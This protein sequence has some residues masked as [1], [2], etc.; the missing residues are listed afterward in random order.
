MACRT[1]GHNRKYSNV[2][3]QNPFQI[4]QRSNK[5]FL[6]SISSNLTNKDT[7]TLLS[8]RSF[9]DWDGVYD[10]PANISLSLCIVLKK[11]AGR[12]PILSISYHTDS[13]SIA[14]FEHVHPPM[15]LYPSNPSWYIKEVDEAYQSLS[16]QE[17]HERIQ[18]FPLDPSSWDPWIQHHDTSDFLKTLDAVFENSQEDGLE[19]RL[20]PGTTKTSKLRKEKTTMPVSPSSSSHFVPSELGCVSYSSTSSIDTPNQSE[21]LAQGPETPISPSELAHIRLSVPKNQKP[22]P[23][24][25]KKSP[26]KSSLQQRSADS[27]G[28]KLRTNDSAKLSAQKVAAK[29]PKDVKSSTDGASET[30]SRLESKP[31]KLFS[32]RGTKFEGAAKFLLEDGILTMDSSKDSEIYRIGVALT[33]TSWESDEDD[34]Q[35][36]DLPT[37]LCRPPRENK[38]L[39]GGMLFSVRQESRLVSGWAISR[40]G[41][42]TCMS[43]APGLLL[44]TFRARGP[45]PTVGI[46]RYSSLY[47]VVIVA[48][49]SARSGVYTA[50]YEVTMRSHRHEI[51]HR[52]ALQAAGTGSSTKVYQNRSDSSVIWLGFIG[53]PGDRAM[54]S[55]NFT[56]LRGSQYAASHIAKVRYST[57]HLANGTPFPLTTVL[58]IDPVDK[59]EVQLLYPESLCV[60]PQ[61]STG[62]GISS[63][64]NN[65]TRTNDTG[66]Q[67]VLSFTAPFSK[68]SNSIPALGAIQDSCLVISNAVLTTSSLATANYELSRLPDK[69][70][71][72]CQL[73]LE[74]PIT[75]GYS[76]LCLELK[77]WT[78][79]CA[80]IHDSL[81]TRIY[82]VSDMLQADEGWM[83]FN[84]ACLLT[85][86]K[87][88][89]E[90]RETTE[91]CLVFRIG[92]KLRIG[93]DLDIDARDGFE[94]LLPRVVGKSFDSISIGT[95]FD[96]CESSN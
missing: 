68:V 90:S 51:P 54:D 79:V 10:H 36:F 48:R 59:V 28:V 19:E 45:L 3:A 52:L 78:T 92:P 80:F 39:H 46:H 84:E 26:D 71:F 69:T 77:G 58:P 88:I 50:N 49:L 32:L 47:S 41:F 94:I 91:I 95:T 24:K 33:I 66:N 9:G 93:T 75:E 67:R 83:D 12:V 60:C 44:G 23:R 4:S 25:S 42:E 11:R 27:S 56:V 15:V 43:L 34:T 14:D 18:H 17:R 6:S 89:S 82:S 96:H 13:V 61:F 5:P 74:L 63:L 72:F 8:L 64:I 38:S 2:Q 87:P 16:E 29:A 35:F 70:A 57:T 85:F 76:H 65:H 31:N 1:V 22:R 30:D 40:K 21:P 37:I 55:T 81:I 7:P 20:T 53:F 86:K 73:Q 62:V